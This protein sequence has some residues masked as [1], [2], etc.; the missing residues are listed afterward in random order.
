MSLPSDLEGLQRMLDTLQEVSKTRPHT[1]CF[2]T[3]VLVFE[4][5]HTKNVRQKCL[6]R[7]YFMAV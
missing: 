4:L 7:R 3:V 2:G 6:H 5:S 1:V